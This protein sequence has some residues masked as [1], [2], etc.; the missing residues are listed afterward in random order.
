MCW[1][2][3]GL[4]LKKSR[5]A[6]ER[7]EVKRAAFRVQIEGVPL[8][9]L[10]FLDECG[11]AL[12]LHR[13]YRHYGWALKGERCFEC[14][15]FNKGKNRSVLGA[16]GWPGATNPTGLW[17]VEQRL[18]A[19]NGDT[20]EEFVAHTLL[21]QLPAGSVLIMDNARIHHRASLHEKVKAANCRIIYLP[22][23]S[24]DFNPI[25]LVW[26]WLKDQVRSLAPR[27]DEERQVCIQAA[28]ACLPPH[29]AKGWF[30]LCG[31]L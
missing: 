29:A 1:G 23:Y 16:Y 28:T 11:F 18:G 12:N 6:Q 17:A 7:C 27:T 4:L 3:S 2:A 5:L 15:P 20:F 30:H 19:W 14:V 10:V 13:L 31:I 24:P 9:K 21:P 22:P 26:S 25:E 8:E